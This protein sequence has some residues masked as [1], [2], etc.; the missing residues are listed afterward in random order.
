M[1]NTALAN[2]SVEYA[3][4]EQTWVLCVRTTEVEEVCGR[5]QARCLSKSNARGFGSE[6]MHGNVEKNLRKECQGH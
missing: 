3:F 6:Y 2:L 4:N 5:A 1:H